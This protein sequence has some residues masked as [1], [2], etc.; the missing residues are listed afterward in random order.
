[1]MFCRSKTSSTFATFPVNKAN[2]FNR[3]PGKTSE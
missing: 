3:K 1:L 2:L